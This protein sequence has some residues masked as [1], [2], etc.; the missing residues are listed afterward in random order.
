VRALVILLL[1]SAALAQDLSVRQTVASGYDVADWK[2]LDL[3]S[4]GSKE[5][6][7]VGGD[8]SIKTWLTENG[9]LAKSPTGALVLPNPT[10]TLLAWEKIINNGDAAQLVALSPKGA[11]VYRVDE[12]GVFR[13]EPELLARRAQFKLR[14]SEP[15]FAG[16]AQDINQDGKLD[17]I[18]PGPKKT[19]VWIH[20]AQGFRRTARIAVEID[21]WDAMDSAALS[22]DLATSFRIPHLRT[23]DVNG[24]G[25]PDLLVK[26][27]RVRSFH[28]QREDGSFPEG[29]DVTLDLRI[30]RD[31]TP[32]AALRPGRTLAGGDRQRYESRDL[33]GDGIPDYVIAHRRKV[34][35]FHGNKD[36]PQFTKPT[37]VLK[38]SHDI[39]V[40]LLLK[41]DKDEFPDLL[42]LKVQVPSAA[43]FVAGLVGGLEIEADALG[44]ASEKGRG[45]ARS[46]G[47]RS[48]ITIQVPSLTKILKDPGKI[49]DR[50]EQAGRKF[51]T[52][53]FADLNGDGIDDTLLR[54]E[55]G[56]QIEFWKGSQK[57][58]MLDLALD[59]T[60]SVRRVLFED[61]NKTWDID[62]LLEFIGS[63]AAK[64]T[65][66]LT[67][68][69]KPDAVIELRD[70]RRFD[71]MNF[72]TGDIDGDGKEEIVV[73]YAP[74]GSTHRPIFDVV[75]LK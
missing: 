17:L 28:L 62:R 29:P 19:E 47:W 44:Y 72:A 35:V 31:T 33:D 59:F 57:L 6:L 74:G 36:K 64:R 16:I 15:T 61:E 45:F 7:L 27:G 39:T 12:R 65:E 8:G 37:T 22:D 60:G 10:R 9:R 30:F 18:V 51:R 54:S 49:I 73:R 21:R 14:V 71:F 42:I 58:A 38:V 34:W 48:T 43:G 50:F 32:K 25:R 5:V 56:R 20:T 69:R 55:D 66:T 46:P 70:P 3:N 13:K 24:D 68:G 75:E 52:H 41:L 4:N 40:M 63:L 11:V 1:A 26:S 23:G 2:L 53:S 67:G